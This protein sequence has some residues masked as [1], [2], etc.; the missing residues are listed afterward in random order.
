M[1]IN[2]ENPNEVSAYVLTGYATEIEVFGTLHMPS[3][4][5]TY[6]EGGYLQVEFMD[7][8]VIEDIHYYD[9]VF[10]HQ[11]NLNPGDNLYKQALANLVEAHEEEVRDNFEY[12]HHPHEGY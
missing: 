7:D 11:I 6:N 9:D 4:W 10:D 1:T 2:T 8:A 5:S 12:I 3:P